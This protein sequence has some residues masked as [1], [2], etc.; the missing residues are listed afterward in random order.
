MIMMM[1]IYSVKINRALARCIR[2]WQTRWHCS[3]EFVKSFW[4]HAIWLSHSKTPRIYGVSLDACKMITSYLLNRQQ[5]VKVSGQVSAWSVINRGV[6]RTTFVNLFLNDLCCFVE[7]N[8]NIANYADDNHLYNENACIKSWYATLKTTQMFVC[9]GLKIT[10]WLQILKSSKGISHPG[11]VKCPFLFLLMV[12]PSYLQ[13]K[14]M[15]WA[16]HLMTNWSLIP[17][18]RAYVFVHQ[19][20]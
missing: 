19:D 11:M 17:T 5:S 8:S 9:L 7:L 18:F 14:L 16:L 6:P 1:K 2:F 4:Q 3:D 12:L 10:I 15:Y 20:K 13:M